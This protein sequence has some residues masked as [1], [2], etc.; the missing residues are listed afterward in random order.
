MNHDFALGKVCDYAAV[1]MDNVKSKLLSLIKVEYT[2]CPLV[3]PPL[4]LLY[5][6]SGLGSIVQRTVPGLTSVRDSLKSNLI[7]IN[8][9]I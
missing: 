3:C 9:I 4:S 5:L 2:L 7:E 1:D 6:I 8:Y